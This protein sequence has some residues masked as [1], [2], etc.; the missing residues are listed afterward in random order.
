MAFISTTPLSVKSL[1]LSSS[2]SS[3]KAPHHLQSFSKP[4]RVFCHINSE[5]EG[6]IL[7]D[8]KED[9]SNTAKP[10]NWR[11]FVSTALAT[12][13]V[14]CSS[15][16]SALADLNKYEAETRGEF[17]IGSAAQFGSA[18]LRKA[19]H[20]NENFRRANFTAADM[21]ES[22]FSGSTFNGAYLE[23]AVAYKANFTGADLSDTLMDRMVLNEAN[24]TNAVLVR[25]VL[26]RSDLGGAIID[27][28]DFSDAVLDLPQKQA[29][30]KYASGTNPVTGVSTR[31]SLGCGNSRR[32][33]YGS[34]SS[35]LI[36][37]PPQ[38]LLDRDGFCDSDTGLCEAK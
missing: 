37:A 36:S 1:N 38:K 13:V 20:A 23:K 3:L 28:A 4:L 10:G 35:P 32:N 22:D 33:A 12:A 31:K 34:P 26:T 29:L 8:E 9:C 14:A 2:S 30:C 17:G 19:V 11:T 16:I 6:L 27:G 7:G 15:D 5:K 18:D 24:L 25:T 21:R